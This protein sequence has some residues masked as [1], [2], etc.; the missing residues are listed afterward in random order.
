[1]A[2]GMRAWFEGG[3]RITLEGAARLDGLLALGAVELADA[4]PLLDAA[5]A[6]AVH[7]RRGDALLE[8][9]QAD[10]APELLERVGRVAGD[11]HRA[12]PPLLRLR[13]GLLRT[14]LG[15]ARAL[16]AGRVHVVAG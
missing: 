12:R 16:G 14:H 1:M 15:R 3:A 8:V 2:G 9:A 13:L 7:A 11:P 10:C 4:N 6:E 5:L